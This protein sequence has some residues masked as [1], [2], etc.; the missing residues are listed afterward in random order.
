VAGQKLLLSCVWRTGTV[1]EER[2]ELHNSGSERCRV[3]AIA[4]DRPWATVLRQRC[5]EMESLYIGSPCLGVCTHCDPISMSH[6]R[7]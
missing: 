3:A 5:A 1:H 2:F 4:V 7:S 6:T